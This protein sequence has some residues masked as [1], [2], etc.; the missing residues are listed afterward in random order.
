VFGS[1]DDVAHVVD[2]ELVEPGELS[3]VHWSSVGP[4]GR[5]ERLELLD[6]DLMQLKSPKTANDP[7]VVVELKGEG[8]S[9]C[10]S[11]LRRFMV[12]IDGLYR[13]NGKRVDIRWDHHCLSPGLVKPLCKRGQFISRSL[14]LADYGWRENSGGQTC[15]LGSRENL[16]H[17]RWYDKRGFNRME[18][19]LHDDWASD[20]LRR[21]IA[22]GP[23][24]FS[25]L[26]VGYLLTAVDFRDVGT[27]TRAHRAARPDWWEAFIGVAEKVKTLTKTSEKR[28]VPA[29]PVGIMDDW[30]KRNRRMF[31]RAELALGKDWMFRRSR[32]WSRERGEMEYGSD[33]LLEPRDQAAVEA[34]RLYAESG[35]C[36]TPN[37]LPF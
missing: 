16:R 8:C 36:G 35:L 20:L 22:C 25:R 6:G 4:V 13:W 15:Y 14:S 30:V 32:Y 23:E 27:V 11:H 31:L 3:H 26:A 21:F 18:L 33:K 37:G 12:A 9:A 5:W 2:R 7:Y 34:L 29:I 28:P 10:Q 17:V 24:D 1:F 19:E